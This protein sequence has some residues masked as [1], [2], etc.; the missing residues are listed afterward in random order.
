MEKKI[1]LMEQYL[2]EYDA[3]FNNVDAG[4]IKFIVPNTMGFVVNVNRL[5][6]ASTSTQKVSENLLLI[7]KEVINQINEKKVNSVIDDKAEFKKMLLILKTEL[8]DFL[9][10]LSAT[11]ETEAKV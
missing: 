2:N 11:F 1:G 8:P 9:E 4:D 5:I 3:M 7:I 10:Q 6:S